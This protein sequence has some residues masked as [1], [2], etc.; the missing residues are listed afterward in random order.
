[1]IRKFFALFA[2]AAMA[3]CS[4][5]ENGKNSAGGD[6]GNFDSVVVTVEFYN[7]LTLP[8][9]SGGE[10]TYTTDMDALNV[11]YFYC[12]KQDGSDAK[13]FK[14]TN[15]KKNSV[16]ITVPVTSSSASLYAGMRYTLKPEFDKTKKVGLA[17]YITAVSYQCYRAGSPVSQPK[18][19]VSLS[20]TPASGSNYDLNDETSAA[21][22]ASFTA[23]AN[24][25]R[26]ICTITKK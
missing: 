17:R 24:E 9:V 8:K 13:Y 16:Q 23:R 21:K 1:M 5:G 6:E 4:C 18:G 14:M 7:E 10:E 2:I 25:P 20:E 3:L 15:Q 19:S 26:K 22:F 11:E 12:F